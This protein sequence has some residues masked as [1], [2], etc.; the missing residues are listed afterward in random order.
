MATARASERRNCPCRVQPP[1]SSKETDD[2]KGQG[3]GERDEQRRGPSPEAASTQYFA[4]DDDG[5]V[6]AARPLALD[7]QR[8]QVR[9]LRRTME[10]IGDVVPQ[11]PALADSVP[12]MV[13][14]LVA[15]LA[16]YDMPIADQLIE[17]PKVSCPHPLRCAVLRTPQTAE[18]Q[19]KVPTILYFS[20]RPLTLVVDL[21]VS[22][23]LSQDRVLPLLPS[24][25]WTFQLQVVV[26]IEVFKVFPKDGVQVISL[27]LA[28]QAHPQYR[29][30]SVGKGFFA[31]SSDSNKCDTTSALW[32]GTA[33]AL[34]PMDAGSS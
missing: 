15:V 24:R 7:E 31:F 26:F 11:V 32:V 21:E 6:L 5:D 3:G 12:Q 8:P 29:V 25:S 14:Q 20:S 22:K 1:L 4:L 27:F 18:Q 34:E 30:M 19:V 16:R 33:S 13:D 10:Q 23:V 9:V 17:V 28:L 2:G